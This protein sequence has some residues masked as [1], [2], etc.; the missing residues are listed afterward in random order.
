V[1][2]SPGPD[3]TTDWWARLPAATSAAAWTAVSTLAEEYARKDPE[4]TVDQ[5]RADAL[6]DLLLTNVTVTAKVTLG[7]PVLTGPDGQTAR[8]AALAQYAAENPTTADDRHSTET[9]STNGDATAAGAAYHADDT[10]PATTC[11]ATTDM[12]DPAWVRPAIATGGQ[13]LRTGFSLSAALISGCEIP[14]IGFIDADTVEALLTVVPTDIGRALLDAR[15]GT[16]IE[17]RSTAY[18]PPKAVTDFVT[19]RDGTCRMWGCNHP[20][21]RCDL[22][23]ARPWPAGPTT[24]SN[25]AGLCRRHH[26]LKQRRRWSYQLAPDGTATWTSP[27]GTTR[28]TQPDFTAPPLPRP[29]PIVLSMIR[30]APGGPPRF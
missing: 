28:I 15:T 8:D 25:L 16:L 14:G 22:D 27:T 29:E 11:P 9:A 17:T 30:L 6:V 7:I 20:T 26:R 19:T 23:H 10:R 12:T 5:A 1:Q 3:G 24:P 13:G 18:R 2:V 21:T 4:L